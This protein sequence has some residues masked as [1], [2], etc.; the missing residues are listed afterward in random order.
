MISLENQSTKLLSLLFVIFSLS[1]ELV[2][3]QGSLSSEDWK[4]LFN[5]N[6]INDWIVKI[7]H[8][9]VEVNYGNTFRVEDEMIKVRYNE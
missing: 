8:H 4:A 6:D 2:S 3:A 7:H 9:E 1:I 5:G